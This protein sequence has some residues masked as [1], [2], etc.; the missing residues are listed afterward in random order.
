MV[1]ASL[2]SHRHP[3]FSVVYQPMLSFREM[4]K[5]QVAGK[6]QNLVIVLYHSMRV[7]TTLFCDMY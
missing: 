6:C 3:H 4:I 7:H 1:D 2:A 5:I